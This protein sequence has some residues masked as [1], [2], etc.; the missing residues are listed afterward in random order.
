MSVNISDYTGGASFQG[1]KLVVTNTGVVGNLNASFLQGKVP[2]DFLQLGN[3]FGI[4]QTAAGNTK[5][6]NVTGVVTNLS[7]SA[8]HVQNSSID[9]DANSEIKIGNLI[10]KSSNGGNGILVGIN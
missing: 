7:S 6:V 4:T 1:D 8:T 10:I 9:F 5:G 2:T 3:N